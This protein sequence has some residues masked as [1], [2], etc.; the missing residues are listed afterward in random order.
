[1]EQFDETLDAGMGQNAQARET[2][3]D[4]SPRLR[5]VWRELSR[6]TLFLSLLLFVTLCAFVL[7]CCFVLHALSRMPYVNTDGSEIVAL[8][9]VLAV[10]GAL[11]FYPAWCYYK[12]SINT[13]LALEYNDTFSLETAS[14]WIKRAYRFVGIMILVMMG[15]YLLLL[16]YFRLTTPELGEDPFAQ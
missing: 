5:P 11:V 2:N 6:W 7:F 14:L 16:L 8:L 3:L 12:F 1:M 4:I 15:L 10:V 13:R 9:L